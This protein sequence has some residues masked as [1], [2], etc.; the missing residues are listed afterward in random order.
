MFVCFFIG[1]E[2]KRQQGVSCNLTL[3]ADWIRLYL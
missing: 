3:D 1:E 2:I